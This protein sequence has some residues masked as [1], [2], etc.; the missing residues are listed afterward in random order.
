MIAPAAGTSISIF[1]GF[2]ET[3]HDISAAAAGNDA[4]VTEQ[5]HIRKTVRAAAAA[6]D[7]LFL[8]F[9]QL[10]AEFLVFSMIPSPIVI[11]LNYIA[12]LYHNLS[13]L[14]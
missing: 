13:K 14:L 6:F 1:T 3:I 7:V 4:P 12:C 5:R 10:T 11:P 8:T 2:R 9:A